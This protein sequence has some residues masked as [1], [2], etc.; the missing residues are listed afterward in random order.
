MNPVMFGL[1]YVGSWLLMGLGIFLAFRVFTE[2]RKMSLRGAAR[3]RVAEAS[4][5]IRIALVALVVLVSIG[6]TY[7]GAYTFYNLMIVR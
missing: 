5:L 4:A 1:T 2:F 7:A 6:V 3:E